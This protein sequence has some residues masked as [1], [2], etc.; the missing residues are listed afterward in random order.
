M[1]LSSQCDV[2]QIGGNCSVVGISRG[3]VIDERVGELVGQFAG[4]GDIFACLIVFILHLDFFRLILDVTNIHQIAIE[5][6]LEIVVEIIFY[7]FLWLKINLL[8]PHRVAGR[9]H[10]LV[11]LIPFGL[12]SRRGRCGTGEGGVGGGPAQ[13]G[14][15]SGE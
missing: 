9:A 12:R 3:G 4:Q 8:A 6:E 15:S 2:Q 14:P 11:H 7:R 5:E 10:L 1:K 13:R